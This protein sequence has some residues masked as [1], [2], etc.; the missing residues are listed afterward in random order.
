[1]GISKY[2]ALGHEIEALMQ[3]HGIT[4]NVR[5]VSFTNRIIYADPLRNHIVREVTMSFDEEITDP[6]EIERIINKNKQI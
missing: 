5:G 3:A 4:L 6:R 2:K 1:M